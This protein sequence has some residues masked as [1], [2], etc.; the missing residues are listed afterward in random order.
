MTTDE[1]RIRELEAK[2]DQRQR[3][4]LVRTLLLSAVPVVMAGLLLWW[5]L[6]EIDDARTKVQSVNNKLDQAQQ[7]LSKTEE[8]LISTEAK[9]KRTQE[10]L[11]ELEE[12]IAKQ[13][14]QFQELQQVEESLK[15]NIDKLI[16]QLKEQETVANIQDI[17]LNVRDE[18]LGGR[19]TSSGRQLYKYTLRISVPEQLQSRITRVEYHFDHPSFSANTL[20]SREPEND[21]A[22]SYIGWGCL[23]LVKTIVSLDDGTTQ[24]VYLNMCK[25]LLS[26]GRVGPGG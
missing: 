22:V 18:V 4:V 19:T 16:V 21:F 12:E 7:K 6:L 8:R 11:E 20:I 14:S 23:A 10:D 24:P 2:F 26:S 5:M 17:T 15:S 9:L 25:A 1:V 3:L 13:N